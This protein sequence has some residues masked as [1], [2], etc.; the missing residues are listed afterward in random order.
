MPYHLPGVMKQH[1]INILVGTVFF[2]VMFLLYN[3]LFQDAIGV[4]ELL[5]TSF[6]ISLGNEFLVPPL[7]KWGQGRGWVAKR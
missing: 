1:I 5:L 6:F 3:L 4:R 2:A 7:V